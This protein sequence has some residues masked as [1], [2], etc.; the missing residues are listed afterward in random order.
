MF[1]LEFSRPLRFAEPPRKLT[2]TL[3][4]IGSHGRAIRRE[5]TRVKK[6]NFLAIKTKTYTHS[7]QGGEG[8]PSCDPGPD[9]QKRRGRSSRTRK[10]DRME[11]Q[12]KEPHFAAGSSPT[13]KRR[14]TITRGAPDT[15]GGQSSSRTDQPTSHTIE[16]ETNVFGKYIGAVLAYIHDRLG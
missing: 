1:G 13:A 12:K 8:C 14:A 7:G 4:G 11:K 16:P 15:G 6:L 10:I 5:W 3:T 2:K 9:V